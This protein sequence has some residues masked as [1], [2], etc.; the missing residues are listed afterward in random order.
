MYQLQIE[1]SPNDGLYEA[2]VQVISGEPHVNPDISRINE[3][4]NAAHCIR[5]TQP[6]LRR[7]CYCL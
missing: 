6:Q 4:G 3:Y 2:T 5:T 1:T 7:F